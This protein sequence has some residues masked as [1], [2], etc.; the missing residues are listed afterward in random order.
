M[1]HRTSTDGSI[2]EE[3]GF[4]EPAVEPPELT[5]I[6]DPRIETNNWRHLEDYD[7]LEPFPGRW[8]NGLISNRGRDIPFPKSSVPLRAVGFPS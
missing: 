3:Q 2:G 7:Y 8:S 6:H 4:F 5:L 1:I